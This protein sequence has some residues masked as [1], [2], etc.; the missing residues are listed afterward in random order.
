[1][2]IFS[3]RAGDGAS[4]KTENG[5]PSRITSLAASRGSLA[6]MSAKVRC[7]ILR[8]TEKAIQIR[9]QQPNREAVEAWIPRSQCDHIS[10][11]PD[12]NVVRGTVTMRTWLADKHN[13]AVEP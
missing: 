10:K 11:M 9:Q 7:I 12:G 2:D 3:L 8:E 13:L 1:M 5:S 6:D 4:C